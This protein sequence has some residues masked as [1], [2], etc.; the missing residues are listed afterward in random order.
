MEVDFMIKNEM[1][2]YA[3]FAFLGLSA[4]CIAWSVAQSSPYA[5]A[6]AGFFFLM[7][8]VMWRHGDSVMT[9]LFGFAG[10][11]EKIGN[12]AVVPQRDAIVRKISDRYIASVFAIGEIAESL[13]DKPSDYVDSYSRNFERAI[14]SLKIPIKFSMMV[15]P[16]DLAVHIDDIKTK[17]SQAE[18]EKSRL[19]SEDKS[20]SDLPKIERKIGMWNKM[21]G[22]MAGGEKPMEVRFYIMTSAGGMTQAESISRARSQLSQ[23][24]AS[25]SAAMGLQ[26][27]GARGDEML[28]CFDSE[29][30]VPKPAKPDFLGEEQ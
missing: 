1:Q 27:R 11:E 22:R 6:A 26:M 28:E 24:M 15:K 19:L 12:F 20:S 9:I 5:T 21:L 2:S 17:R 4:L 14:T 7:T 25:I 8:Y 29:F 10:R 3:P 13:D 16:V 30:F 23:A 18:L